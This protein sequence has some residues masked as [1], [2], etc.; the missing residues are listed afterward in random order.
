[1]RRVFSLNPSGPAPQEPA[2]DRQQQEEGE[3][4]PGAPTDA[5]VGL[6][7]GGWRLVLPGRRPLAEHHGAG[8]VDRLA[9][10]G[11]VEVSDVV[12]CPIPGSSRL[13]SVATGTPSVSVTVT[14]TGDVAGAVV[15]QLYI[16]D[17]VASMVRPVRELKGFAK[18]RLEPG[19]QRTVQF[20]LGPRELGFYNQ[21]MQWVV[22]P[23]GF[24][25]WVG[26]NAVE[27]LEGSFTV[28]GN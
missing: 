19:E 22:E 5:A 18:V 26:W 24:M 2:H 23:G 25:V 8:D 17:P 11:D 7:F 9:D 1:M 12:D 15:V 10:L 20:T 14:N 27:G 16:R 4:Q 13:D 3:Q 21:D 6:V 28:R